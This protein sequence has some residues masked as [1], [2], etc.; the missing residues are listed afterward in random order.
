MYILQ[1]SPPPRQCT[2]SLSFPIIFEPI[3]QFVGYKKPR[4]RANSFRQTLRVCH[5][6]PFCHL[7]DIF[8]R[9]GEVF[10]IEGGSGETGSFAA[11]KGSLFEG[12]VAAGDWGV[13]S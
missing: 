3:R 7:R 5:C 13:C 12:A 6:S 4:S 1:F 2:D 11:G 10:L 8:P 9:P